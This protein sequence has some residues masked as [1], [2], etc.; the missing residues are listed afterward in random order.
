MDF[1]G[2]G[3]L[4][5]IFILLI[6]LI[7]FGPKDIIKA[8]QSAGRFLRKMIMSPGWRAV[9]QTSRDLR[10]LPNKLM[11]EAGVDEI[12][13][14]L[15]KDVKDFKEMTTPPDLN[16]EIKEEINKIGEG[17][18][19]WTSPPPAELKPAETQPAAVKPDSTSDSTPSPTTESD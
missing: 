15:G 13:Q 7:I 16:K 11:R 17:L 1:L 12:K 3:P 4:E 18:S 10:N 19:A 8:S 2:I 9:Q 14:D 6:A 5:I